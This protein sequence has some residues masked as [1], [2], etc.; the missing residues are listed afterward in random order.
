MSSPTAHSDL[1]TSLDGSETADRA[2]RFGGVARLYA[3]R[4][5]LRSKGPMLL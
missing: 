3:R 1:T 5:S 2:R 4:R